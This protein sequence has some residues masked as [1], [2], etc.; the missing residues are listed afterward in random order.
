MIVGGKFEKFM[1]GPTQPTHNRIHVT[2]NKEFV[3]GLSQ[4]CY[5]LLGKPPAVYLHYNREE[6]I[7]GIEAVHSFRMPAAFPVKE[8][9]SVGWRINS[10]PFCKH[11]NLRIDTTEKFVRPQLS[12]DGK[13][14][15]L[16]LTETVTMRQFR[17]KNKG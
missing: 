2:I 14:L 10:A 6:H 13:M 9:N 3:I 5:K 4:N 17:R 16:K 15:L 7:I 12:S 8:K 11:Y 1:G